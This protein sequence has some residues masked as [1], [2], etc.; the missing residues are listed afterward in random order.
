MLRNLR[1]IPKATLFMVDTLGFFE[2]PGK[3]SH[4]QEGKDDAYDFW[5]NLHFLSNLS[6]SFA[7]S[8]NLSKYILQ[9]RVQPFALY[10]ER[11]LW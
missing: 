1:L 8:N 11:S 9:L 6:L 4:C 10:Q 3:N 5:K 2:F 7:D